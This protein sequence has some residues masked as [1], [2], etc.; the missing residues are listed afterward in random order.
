MF[1]PQAS[2][3]RETSGDIVKCLLFSQAEC[4][5][6]AKCYLYLLLSFASLEDG[7]T[8]TTTSPLLSSLLCSQIWRETTA[9]VH[10]SH[11]MKDALQQSQTKN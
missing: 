7:T 5:A 9:I 3:C 10:A 6:L 4:N 11:S 2:F 8:Q 1:I